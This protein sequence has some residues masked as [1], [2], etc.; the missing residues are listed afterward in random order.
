MNENIKQIQPTR[1]IQTAAWRNRTK[2]RIRVADYFRL[3]TIDGH[4]IQLLTLQNTDH[5]TESELVYLSL[6]Q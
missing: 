5:K 3:I 4:M 2:P 1:I 6:L